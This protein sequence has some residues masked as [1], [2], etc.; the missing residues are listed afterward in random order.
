MKTTAGFILLA[1]SFLCSPI[2]QADTF[3]SG[4]NE[5]TIEFVPIGD[6]NN[7]DDTTGVPNPAG[8]VEYAYRM[9]KFE[10]S[11]GMIDKANTLGG[12]GITHNNRGTNKPATSISW[13]EAAKFINWL[14]TS[15]GHSAAYKF[16]GGTFELWRSGDAG[17][18]SSNPFRNSD[19]F[20]FLPTADEWYKAAYY[21]SYA[22][23]YY[24]FPTG[25][26]T[27]PTAVANGTAPDTAVYIQPFDQG[28]ADINQ[29]GGRSPYGTMGQ[30]GNAWEWEETEFD[31][32]NDLSDSPR[33]VRGG[34]WY[35]T[36]SHLG[37]RSRDVDFPSLEYHNIGFRVASIPEPSTALLGVFA[38][39]WLMVWRRVS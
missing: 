22:G 8:K 29:T 33:G 28:P 13:F 34:G 12:L 30:G 15:T 3:G 14:N 31:L 17:Y 20:Y 27:A 4:A 37:A 16:N 38:A 35:F 10:I 25:S 21:D 5:F 2:A 9:G 11:E 23:E 18:D 1:L 19:A 6:P 24:D 32:I 36:T 26:D 7:P 39:G